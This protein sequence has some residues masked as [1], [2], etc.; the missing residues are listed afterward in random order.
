[1]LFGTDFAV[2]RANQRFATVFGGAAED[3]RGRTV[4]DYLPQA[5]ADRLSATLK[6]V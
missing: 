1:M 5:E 4:D 6:R 2:V 3:H